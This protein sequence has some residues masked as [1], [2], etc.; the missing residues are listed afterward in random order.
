VFAPVFL[1]NLRSTGLPRQLRLYP[2]KSREFRSSA[3]S[4]RIGVQVWCVFR[5]T[6]TCRPSRCN[7]NHLAQPG[8]IGV[9]RFLDTVHYQKRTWLTLVKMW[10]FQVGSVEVRL[11]RIREIITYLPVSLKVVAEVTRG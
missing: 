10:P 8:I 7:I 6:I 3:D 2:A 1:N 5:T 4:A 11:Y 9:P